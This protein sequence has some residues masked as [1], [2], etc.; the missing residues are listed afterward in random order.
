MDREAL[1]DTATGPEGSEDP[2]AADLAVPEVVDLAAAEPDQDPVAEQEA[3]AVVPEASAPA[4]VVRE[5]QA[6][7]RI[8]EQRYPRLDRWFPLEA[9][10]EFHRS[11]KT[12]SVPA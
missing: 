2:V 12:I 8:R 3:R 11:L 9:R 4:A 10:R 1:R 7:V 5:D 6:A